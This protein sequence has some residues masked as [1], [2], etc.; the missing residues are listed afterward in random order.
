VSTGP[1]KEEKTLLLVMDNIAIDLNGMTL[2]ALQDSRSNEVYPLPTMLPRTLEQTLG[3]AVEMKTE[4]ERVSDII[5]RTKWI[6]RHCNLII[7]LIDI[8]SLV[9]SLQMIVSDLKELLAQQQSAPE[10]N[11]I[12]YA[13][14][15]SVHKSKFTLVLGAEAL[16]ITIINKRSSRDEAQLYRAICNADYT[17]YTK[18]IGC[19]LIKSR[20]YLEVDS[21]VLDH[22]QMINDLPYANQS[23][24]IVMPRSP[25]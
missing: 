9:P 21:L 11:E 2:I 16:A 23:I 15:K 20:T 17:N 25:L 1:S 22:V 7:Y 5:K 14:R 24:L 8:K 6:A 3:F 19:D 13:E 12:V 10:S 4:Q 18:W